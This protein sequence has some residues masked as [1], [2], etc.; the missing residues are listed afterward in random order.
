MRRADF[1]L[2][3]AGSTARGGVKKALRE[4]ES[5]ATLV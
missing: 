4:T 1:K 3:T 5:S 2:A